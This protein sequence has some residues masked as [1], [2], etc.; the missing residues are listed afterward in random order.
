MK[1]LIYIVAAAGLTITSCG[2]SQSNQ[3]SAAE[4]TA[5]MQERLRALENERSDAFQS[6]KEK[7]VSLM[8]S[9]AKSITEHPNDAEQYYNEYTQKLDEL[10][11]GNPEFIQ[12]LLS[13]STFT[14]ADKEFRQTLSEHMPNI[15]IDA[16]GAAE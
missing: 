10:R 14:A 6:F 13:D 12:E 8:Q 11:M 9:A 4:S 7:A 16:N 15:A 5:V 1:L 2:K 3:D